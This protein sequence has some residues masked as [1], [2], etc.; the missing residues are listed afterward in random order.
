MY[1]VKHRCMIIPNETE[2][3]NEKE[4]QNWDGRQT[5]FTLSGPISSCIYFFVASDSVSH[6]SLLCVCECMCVSV[7]VCVCMSVCVW[8]CVL[9]SLCFLRCAGVKLFASFSKKPGT[10]NTIYIF[11][12]GSYYMHYKLSFTNSNITLSHIL[13]FINFRCCFYIFDYS[14]Q[15]FITEYV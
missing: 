8:L 9:N 13:S 3:V 2:H 5:V 15:Q 7:C 11:L 12:R 6:L 10:V 1:L 4:S 14:V